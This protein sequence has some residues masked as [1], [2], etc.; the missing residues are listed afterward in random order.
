MAADVCAALRWPS[1]GRD[2]E[3]AKKI[4]CFIEDH[5]KEA[6]AP[7]KKRPVFKRTDSHCY[8]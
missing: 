2:A 4:A 5:G 8:G 6:I 1:I 7:A 3:M